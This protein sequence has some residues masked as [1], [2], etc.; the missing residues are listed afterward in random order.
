VQQDFYCRLRTWTG[1][2]QL[3]IGVVVAL[4]CVVVALALPRLQVV[5]QTEQEHE[6]YSA[7]SSLAANVMFAQ[8]AWQQQGY[9]DG[10]QI[11]DLPKFLQQ[12]L[13]MTFNGWPRGS[14]GKEN[15]TNMDQ[16]ACRE[17]WQSLVDT[18]WS[19]SVASI[20]PAGSRCRYRATHVDGYVDYDVR[21]GRVTLTM[22]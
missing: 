14:S 9:K 10:D 1:A 2:T 17:V 6:L 16:L 21:R 8:Q 3:E 18:R 7:A 13:N 4:F 20:T 15:H 22:S 19:S 5:D 11:D 12:N